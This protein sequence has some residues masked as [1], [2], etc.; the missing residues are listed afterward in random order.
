LN[1]QRSEA[2]ASA[3]NRYSVA[4][5]AVAKWQREGRQN[6]FAGSI[7]LRAPISVTNFGLGVTRS[8]INK[9][10][11]HQSVL[12]FAMMMNAPIHFASRSNTLDWPV[13]C[14]GSPLRFY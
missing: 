1:L 4:Y 2:E 10:R 12:N 7:P 8:A 13:L 11:G 3:T 9:N 5:G 6:L 14:C